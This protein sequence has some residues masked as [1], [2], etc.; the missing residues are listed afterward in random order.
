MAVADGSSNFTGFGQPQQL[1]L[2]I[3]QLGQ[4]QHPQQASPRSGGMVVGGRAGTPQSPHPL[5][6]PV[7]HMGITGPLRPTMNPQQQQPVHPQRITPQV[8]P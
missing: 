6:S 7:C 4:Q 8:H 3:K 1:Q 5:L 2:Q